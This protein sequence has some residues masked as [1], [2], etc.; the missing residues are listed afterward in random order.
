[1]KLFVEAGLAHEQRFGDGQ[2][3]YEVVDLSNDHHDHIICRTCG[4][5]FE[6]DDEELERRQAEIASAHGLRIVAHRHEIWGE[7]QRGATCPHRSATAN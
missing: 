4:H 3:R 7:C 2:T 5:I 6:F 1:M